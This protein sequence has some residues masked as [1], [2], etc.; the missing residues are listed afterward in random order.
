[1]SNISGDM[2]YKA[3]ATVDNAQQALNNIASSLGLKEPTMELT[4]S[5][6][7]S[8]IDINFGNLHIF[9]PQDIDYTLSWVL[10]QLILKSGY[11]WTLAPE[12]PDV[13][14]DLTKFVFHYLN[15]YSAY[16]LT[17]S[18]PKPYSIILSGK[19]GM[20]HWDFSLDNGEP[21]ESQIKHA[22]MHT[23]VSDT[24]ELA[25]IR[26]VVQGT[27]KGLVHSTLLDIPTDPSTQGWWLE[28]L[29]KGVSERV[30]G[31]ESVRELLELGDAMEKRNSAERSSYEN[32]PSTDIFSPHI[33]L[34]S[35][36]VDAPTHLAALERKYFLESG[37]RIQ[38]TNMGESTA[39]Y[40]KIP[41]MGKEYFYSCPYTTPINFRVESAKI[42]ASLAL[43][44]NEELREIPKMLP[45]T[46]DLLI[47][48]VIP[49]STVIMTWGDDHEKNQ[50]P[51]TVQTLPKLIEERKD[52]FFNTVF[53]YVQNLRTAHLLDAKDIWVSRVED[54]VQLIVLG[55]PYTFGYYRKGL[56]PITEEILKAAESL[57]KRGRYSREVQNQQETV[58]A[59]LS[60]NAVQAV[61]VHSLEQRFQEYREKHGLSEDILHL[62]G[63]GDTLE[64]SLYG[65]VFPFPKHDAD[66]ERHLDELRESF[67]I[68]DRWTVKL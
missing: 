25:R 17:V 51:C 26:A 21:L 29:Y 18:F 40:V 46:D 39:L 38:F 24:P 20:H 12:Q 37:A 65:Q 14:S 36:A 42:L 54:G 31:T 41:Y 30:T 68:P 28:I 56:P 57:L 19:H 67:N 60:N 23:A 5:E 44:N 11:K 1:M 6:G 33:P 16:G 13:D 58:H 61:R 8:G 3:L 62:G 59:V 9:L 50:Q 52:A 45:A 4:F 22:V 48:D 55:T 32:N 66:L 27:S 43:E 34:P 7:S 53:N 15:K 63:F 35:A 64:I 49:P 2:I 47:Y 10:H